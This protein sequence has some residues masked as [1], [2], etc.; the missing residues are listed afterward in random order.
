MA[1]EGWGVIVLGMRK[2]C[3]YDGG[4]SLCGKRAFYSGPLE[5]DEGPTTD[6]CTPCRQKLDKRK[7]AASG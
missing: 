3:Y 5:E 6:D 2:A 4:R 7:A 1:N